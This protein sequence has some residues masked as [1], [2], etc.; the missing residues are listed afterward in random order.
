MRLLQL[1]P[2]SLQHLAGHPRPNPCLPAPSRCAAPNHKVSALRPQIVVPS[3]ACTLSGLF[4]H[5]PQHP[6]CSPH[7]TTQ[8]SLPGAL[9]S[10]V[11]LLHTSVP[12]PNRLSTTLATSPPAPNSFVPD[13]WVEQTLPPSTSPASAS[14]ILVLRSCQV[15]QVLSSAPALPPTAACSTSFPRHAGLGNSFPQLSFLTPPQ[16]PCQQQPPSVH[17]MPAQSV[18]Q[19]LLSEVPP[20]ASQS[21]DFSVA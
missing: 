18:P 21:F 12:P 6:T 16:Q 13:R 1:Q 5:C 20:E 15:Q 3:S 14:T 4:P 2:P 11:R 19:H 10:P 7:A 17:S 9:Q 8:T